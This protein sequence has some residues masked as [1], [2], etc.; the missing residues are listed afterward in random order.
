MLECGGHPKPDGEES[1]EGT[2]PHI[3]L[4]SHVSKGM[5][6]GSAVLRDELEWSKFGAL[7]K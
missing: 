6:W 3:G 1:T 2:A 4:Y 7:K 5:C